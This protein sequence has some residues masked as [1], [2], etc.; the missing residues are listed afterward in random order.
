MARGDRTVIGCV[1]HA[2]RSLDHLDPAP[3]YEW[4]EEQWNA[5]LRRTAP[6]DR[7]LPA[8][9]TQELGCRWRAQQATDRRDRGDLQYHQLSIPHLWGPA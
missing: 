6:G 5:G 2:W 1:W 7:A 4:C 9:L 8:W 3:S